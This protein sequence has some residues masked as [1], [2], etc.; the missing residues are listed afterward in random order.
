MYKRKK[1][2]EIKI[3]EILKKLIEAK[4]SFSPKSSIPGK[5][6]LK[7]ITID[8]LTTTRRKIYNFLYQLR[9]QG[10]LNIENDN[11]ELIFLIFAREKYS[12]KK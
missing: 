9:K 2:I 7:G 8:V 1:L 11:N 10:W 6:H 5:V 3:S 4:I 12:R